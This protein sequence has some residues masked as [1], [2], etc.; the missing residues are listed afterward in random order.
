MVRFVR[1]ADIT[2]RIFKFQLVIITKADNFSSHHILPDIG[3]YLQRFSI[4]YLYGKREVS[5]DF[6]LRTSHF[7]VQTSDF[8]IVISEFSQVERV[9]YNI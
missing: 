1:F 4:I 3:Y 8:G 2:I 5:S 9:K 6:R 7:E